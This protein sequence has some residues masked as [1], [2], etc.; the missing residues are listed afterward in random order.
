MDLWFNQLEIEVRGAKRKVSGFVEIRVDD[1]ALRKTGTNNWTLGPV[2][3]RMG[4][5][6]VYADRDTEM[7]VKSSILLL[8][9]ATDKIRAMWGKS[10]RD[11]REGFLMEA[12]YA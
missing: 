7:L 8:P 9:G 2:M 5:H 3:I 6:M 10:H 11:E 1:V 12:A 4:D